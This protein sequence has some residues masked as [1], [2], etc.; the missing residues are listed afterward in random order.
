MYDNAIAALLG[1]AILTK[2]KPAQLLN[3][4]L[5]QGGAISANET[6]QQHKVVGRVTLQTIIHVTG[7]RLHQFIGLLFAFNCKLLATKSYG[8]VVGLGFASVMYQGRVP[9]VANLL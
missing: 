2:D 1:A 5:L 8:I 4:Y 7:T 9:L 6:H 3:Q